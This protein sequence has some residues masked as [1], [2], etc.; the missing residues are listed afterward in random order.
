MI[1]DR[2]KLRIKITIK[3][4]SFQ[5]RKGNLLGKIKPNVFE[6]YFKTKYLLRLSI[7]TSTVYLRLNFIYV[8]FLYLPRYVSY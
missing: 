8:F 2:S 1:R 6:K 4:R 7:R 5:K 3:K